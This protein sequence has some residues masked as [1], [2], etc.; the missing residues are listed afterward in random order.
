MLYD[1]T[2]CMKEKTGHTTYWSVSHLP[3]SSGDRQE[4]NK[5][6]LNL[7]NY[8]EQ[9]PPDAPCCIT[10]EVPPQASLSGF[11]SE[12]QERRLGGDC[13]FEMQGHL[14][15]EERREQLSPQEKVSGKQV[16]I[17]LILMQETHLSYGLSRSKRP[18]G[19]TRWDLPWPRSSPPGESVGKPS[20]GTLSLYFTSEL[21]LE[22]HIFSAPPAR[23]PFCGVQTLW[24]IR[25]STQERSLASVISVGKASVTFL[26][27][28][29][30]KK[31]TQERN[32][33]NVTSVKRVSF[34]GQT[35][36]DTSG[37]IQE[38]N[39]INAPTVGKVSAGVR[40][41]INI[42]NPIWGRSPLNNQTLTVPFWLSVQWHWA[43]RI[44]CRIAS[45]YFRGLKKGELTV[46]FELGGQIGLLDWISHQ[47]YDLLLS[48]GKEWFSSFSPSP[49]SVSSV[50]PFGGKVSFED[51][52]LEV[53]SGKRAAE[54]L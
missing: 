3:S 20:I 5:E 6:N 24:S 32:P 44:S 36:I 19:R 30:M 9:Q 35:L 14:Q 34:R 38:R 48:Q 7:E 13:L 50:E 15:G 8:R 2:W 23:K 49:C 12:D 16:S 31:S 18:L 40:A 46:D 37:S 52:A 28:A 25:E 26:D 43:F 29:T 42:S 53:S 22:K 39:P 1:D 51:W 54:Q 17:C 4:N 27:Y 41:L 11:F 21:T 33:I 45:T 10:G 47:F